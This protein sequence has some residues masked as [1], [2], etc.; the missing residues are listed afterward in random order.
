MKRNFFDTGF[1][2]LAG[3][4]GQTPNILKYVIENRNSILSSDELV[5]MAQ[6][7]RSVLKNPMAEMFSRM[8]SAKQLSNFAGLYSKDSGK[9]LPEV[10]ASQNISLDL[11]QI[12]GSNIVSSMPNIHNKLL[13]N[14][15]PLIR[16]DRVTH[17]FT[18]SAVD[19]L[20]SI[21][22]REQLVASYYDRDTWLN[23]EL[24]AY[25]VKTYSMT[26]SSAISRHFGLSVTEGMVVAGIFAIFMCQ[27]LED[28]NS[29]Y[30]ALLN[31][32]DFLGSR[33]DIEG[34]ASLCREE[35]SKGL[36]LVSVCDLVAKMVGT[37]LE[38]FNLSILKSIC[39][40]LGS[41]SIATFIAL[42]YP[43]YWT[44]LVVSALS[45][46]KIPLSYALNNVKLKQDGQT[47]FIPRLML[48][49]PLFQVNR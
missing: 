25:V 38:K 28:G 23:P 8:V 29:Y 43:P 17:K 16:E 26:I 7:I 46:S 47:K 30:P 20:Q 4:R 6:S 44:W 10:A 41:N 48:Y 32:C 21:F 36:T 35:S 18:V 19:T 34:L 9:E 49:E 24:S 3:L 15:T 45:G 12:S 1:S 22:C 2:T 40:N 5:E 31:R 11:K 27:M 14:L 42:E 39:G 37:R 13:V 33:K